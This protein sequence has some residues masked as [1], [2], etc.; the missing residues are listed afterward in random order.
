MILNLLRP[1]QFISVFRIT[2]TDRFLSDFMKKKLSHIH[3]FFSGYLFWLYILDSIHFDK[4]YIICSSVCIDK[5]S[6]CR[7]VGCWL[8]NACRVVRLSDIKC[9]FVYPI[10]KKMSIWYPTNIGEMLW[11]HFGKC[12]KRRFLLS[13]L[14]IFSMFLQ[15]YH[16]KTFM[17]HLYGIQLNIHLLWIWYLHDIENQMEHDFG[18]FM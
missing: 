7:L 18:C 17:K 5:C 2:L 1:F 11:K 9:H 13:R 8:S 10:S 4:A 15:K 14:D 6:L 3:P 16:V 12:L